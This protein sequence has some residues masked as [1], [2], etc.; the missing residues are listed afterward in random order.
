MFFSC[1]VA[2]S[3]LP[4]FLPTIIH[5]YG[6]LAAYDGYQYSPKN[7]MDYSAL[8][9]QALSAPPYLLAFV[10]VLLTAHFSDRARARARYIIFHAILAALGYAL[11]SLRGYLRAPFAY[12]YAAVYPAAAGFFSAITLIMTWTLNNQ[13]SD[14]K[15]GTG[16][17]IMNLIGQL[18]P[19]LGTRLYPDSDGPFYV[20]EMAVCGGFMLLVAGL[21][22]WLK[23]ILAR[24]NR[25]GG[26]GEEGELEEEGLLDGDVRTEMAKWGNIL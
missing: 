21:A 3:S 15:R 13:N 10:F 17:A 11:L 9:S 18:G 22:W 12:R 4:P 25:R 5:E 23:G 8:T 24:E 1:N 14:E 2:F 7:R 6:P 16:V 19:L 26:Q 20:R